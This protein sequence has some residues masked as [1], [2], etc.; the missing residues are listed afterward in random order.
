MSRRLRLAFEEPAVFRAEY[1]RN[2]SNGGAF[3]A[4]GEEC[5]LREVVEVELALEFCGESLTLEAEV[6]HVVPGASGCGLAVQFLLPASELRERLAPLVPEAGSA[7]PAPSPP[8]SPAEVP[9]PELELEED[10]AGTFTL[11]LDDLEGGL[12]AALGTEPD[13]AGASSG[14]GREEKTKRERPEERE[15]RRRR[16]RERRGSSRGSARLPA[17]VDAPHVSIDG[18][19]R[20]LSESGVLIS[21]D[22]SELPV[23]KRVALSLRHPETGE[24]VQVAGRVTRHEQGEGAVAAVAIAF[25]GPHDDPAL[26]AFVEAARESE[27]QRGREGIRGNIDEIG[28]ASLLQMLAQSSRQGTLTVTRGSEEGVVAFDG[29]RLRYARLGAARG[30]KALMRL[31]AWPEGRFVFHAAV[32]PLDEEDEPASLDA[33][34]LDAARVLDEAAHAGGPALDPGA[35]FRLDRGALASN[36][37]LS[38]TEEAV[39]D[40]AAADFTVRR[41]LDVIPEDDGEIR[42][43][44]G[45]LV[46]KGVIVPRPA[47]RA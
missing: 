34:L 5:E 2:I 46:E 39:V 25:E 8:E 1:E 42:R 22:A 21:A 12:G 17:R 19:T 27:A 41:M 13:A 43:A 3:V 20:D 10:E 9:E 18:R 7:P 23:G 40:L 6:V 26:A 32:D 31:V 29:G 47:S 36:G 38:K 30:R 37:G 15:A 11:D 16:R 14:P 33:L 24:R 45:A 35:S 4:E 28:M 44:I